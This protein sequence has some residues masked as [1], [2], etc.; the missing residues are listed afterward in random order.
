MFK[1]HTLKVRGVIRV[2]LIMLQRSR[3][4]S[5]GK[6]ACITTTVVIVHA[7]IEFLALFRHMQFVY[8]CYE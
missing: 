7:I 2:Q 6:R 1:V 5:G 4:K 8:K 3:S